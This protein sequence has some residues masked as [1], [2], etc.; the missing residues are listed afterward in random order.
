[1]EFEPMP[2]KVK[3]SKEEILKAA[4]DITRTQGFSAV[5]A[6]SIAKEIG[7]STH[8]IFRVYENMSSL[9]E[10]LFR[11][12]ENYYNQFL[13]QRI[14]GKDDIFYSI[15]RSYI[16]FSR[17]EKHLFQMLFMSDNF[18][19]NDLMELIDS[20]DNQEIISFISLSANITRE[21]AKDLYLKTWLFTHGIASM[22]STNSINLND[23]QI[24]RLIK[25]AYVSFIK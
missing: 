7:C 23:A 4:F 22:L 14:A 18:K 3:V 17:E 6:R 19:L 12:I 25:D 13:E 20:E 16:E 5:N 9:K 24:E 2:P 1:M 10:D 8:P 15:G 21:K 11:F